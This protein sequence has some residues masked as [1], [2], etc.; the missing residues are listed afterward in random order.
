M[1]IFYTSQLGLCMAW[2]VHSHAG[3]EAALLDGPAIRG[4][5]LMAV[6][7]CFVASSLAFPLERERWQCLSLRQLKKRRGRKERKREGEKICQITIFHS[8]LDPEVSLGRKIW[9]I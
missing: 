4:L 9:K 1:S 3:L 8:W 2:V 6:A 5:P 7:V